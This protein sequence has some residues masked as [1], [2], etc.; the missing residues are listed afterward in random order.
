MTLEA[1]DTRRVERAK[2]AVGAAFTINGL[3]VASWISRVPAARDDL[4]VSAA[5]LGL[6]LL[7]MSG[8]SVLALPA[9]SSRPHTGSSSGSRGSNPPTCTCTLNTRVPPST[10]S[11]T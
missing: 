3:A 10:A 2:V 7:C 1:A 9:S 11:A 6:L 4:G 8:G 5:Q